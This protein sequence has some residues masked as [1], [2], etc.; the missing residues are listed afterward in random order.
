MRFKRVFS[1]TLALSYTTRQSQFVF[2]YRLIYG[3]GVSPPF[4][5]LP[6]NSLILMFL[7]V[8]D[9]NSKVKE[10]WTK[11]ENIDKLAKHAILHKNELN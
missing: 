1:F 4:I 9:K 11:I 6:K 5:N 2:P 8:T 3:R 7:S 10:I